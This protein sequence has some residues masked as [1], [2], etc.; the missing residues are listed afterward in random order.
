MT[1]P[2]IDMVCKDCG[3]TYQLSQKTFDA[4]KKDPN[5]HWR[6]PSCRNKFFAEV[7]KNARDNM[8]DQ[9]KEEAIRK[10]AEG[11]KKRL[12]N[13]TEEEKARYRE[14]HSQ[15]QKNRWAKIPKEERLNYMSDLKS[16][17]NRWF[18]NM[19]DDEK[20]SFGDKVREGQLNMSAEERDR[21]LKNRGESRKKAWELLS[22]E[23]R[24]RLMENAH[25][26]SKDWWANLSDEERQ[27]RLDSVHA[28]AEK[29]RNGLSEEEWEKWN[30]SLRNSLQNYWD[31]ISDEEKDE[32]MLALYEG[33]DL[34]WENASDEIRNEYRERGKK[35]S[36]IQKEWWANLPDSKKRDF[37][38]KRKDYWDNLP[39]SEK[40]RIIHK[41]V[42]PRNGTNSLNVQFEETFTNHN[43]DKCFVY[44]REY[45][46]FNGIY[47]HSWDYGIF[48]E[49]GELV[50]LVDMDG[51]YYHADTCDY[52]GMHSKED[53]DEKRF[54][55]LPEG[56]KF[57]I[58]P[59]NNFDE[60]F[61]FMEHLLAI[62]FDQYCDEL[63][64]ELRSQPFPEPSRTDEELMKS[65]DTLERM[66][67]YDDW[68][69]DMSLETHQGDWL[70]LSFHQSIWT[71]HRDGELSPYETWRNDDMLKSMIRSHQIYHT[72]I[73][74][75]KVSQCFNSIRVQFMSGGR[76]KMIIAKYLMDYNEIFDPFSGYSGRMLGA[77]SL[78]KHYIGQDTSAVRVNESNR[79]L[80]FLHKY[81][82]HFNATI[83]QNDIHHSSGKYECL[84]TCTPSGDEWID[85]CLE[86]FTCK[87]YAFIV[88]STDKYKHYIDCSLQ[89]KS[90]YANDQYII[91]ID[92]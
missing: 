39:I 25:A 32:R 82:I 89:N 14:A 63:F 42:S 26:A 36:D 31:N 90:Y 12:Q 45:K 21:M 27:R 18:E 58:I 44:V 64:K 86:R 33:R 8:T 53:C 60:G 13:M 48:D 50:M 49:N 28:D 3:S 57:C 74:K 65:Y 88:D 1:Y 69:Q 61:K 6:C 47:L 59:E 80:Q 29:W 11:H 34:W 52:D 79:L 30:G 2:K 35:L 91:I 4:H 71:D 62:S 37:A 92:K 68:H 9:Q 46:S 5:Y 17:Y 56:M 67:P 24:K 75:N 41:M 43:L 19:S 10:S 15:G 85:L 55:S 66:D 76:A 40:K 22:P 78:D 23:E 84:F 16:G 87:R 51:A 77:I 72:F 73:N 7:L 38:Q 81:E 83:S 54:L 70:I 20:K